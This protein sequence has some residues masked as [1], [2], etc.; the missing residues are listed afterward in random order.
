LD[1]PSLAALAELEGLE[2]L[3]VNGCMEGVDPE[4]AVRFGFPRRLE[5]LEFLS[6]PD[7]HFAAKGFPDLRDLPNLRT[8]SL[9]GGNQSEKFDEVFEWTTES[10]PGKRRLRFRS[11]RNID[12]A[13]ALIRV[14]R[15]LET[16]RFRLGWCGKGFFA[17]LREHPS[18]YELTLNNAEISEDAVEALLSAPRL[19]R[20]YIQ[21]PLGSRKNVQRLREEFSRR[22]GEFQHGLGYDYDGEHVL[23][24]PL[25]WGK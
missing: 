18:L 13:A 23:W 17:A 2:R 16:F 3:T 25:E 9:T 6:Y 11:A 24:R 8:F 15:R 19:K 12:S 10:V 14:S 22:G 4:A 5:R 20:I 21:C 1:G 7:N